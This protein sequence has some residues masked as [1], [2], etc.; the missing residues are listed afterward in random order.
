MSLERI[1][2]GFEHEHEWDHGA[3]LGRE[4]AGDGDR[5]L[6]PEA[7]PAHAPATEHKPDPQVTQRSGKTSSQRISASNPRDDQE[8]LATP[9]GPGNPM[10]DAKVRSELLRVAADERNVEFPYEARITTSRDPLRMRASASLSSAIVAHMPKGAKVTVTGK[11]QNHFRPIRY[12]DA[13]HP[14]KTWEGWAFTT[15]LSPPKLKGDQPGTPRV[16]I[17][18]VTI[19][20]HAEVE[21]IPLIPS[22]ITG[23]L[24]LKQP[25]TPEPKIADTDGAI[26][27]RVVDDIKKLN[28]P[29]PS[30]T[31][32][33]HYKDQYRQALEAAGR[34]AEWDRR[35][36]K[37]HTDSRLWQQPYELDDP[38]TFALVKGA[39]ASEGLRQFLAG[40]TVTDCTTAMVAIELDAVRAVVGDVVFDRCFGNPDGPAKIRQ[41]KISQRL[42]ETPLYE[43][44]RFTDG[45]RGADKQRGEMGKRPVKAGEWYY[46]FNHPDYVEKHP[47]GAWRG[48]NALCLGEHD[49]KQMWSGFGETHDEEGMLRA[50]LARYNAPR[51]DADFSWLDR[52]YTIRENWP[53]Q[54]LD[55]FSATKPGQTPV[56][57]NGARDTVNVDQLIAAQKTPT[58][59]KAKPGK[60]QPAP[61]LLPPKQKHAAGLDVSTGMVLSTSKLA[62]LVRAYGDE[63]PL[64]HAL[65]D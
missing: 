20:V 61:P 38:F 46:F 60:G 16:H 55:G 5:E 8:A 34:S 64:A 27:V 2:P 43:L 33:L 50:L 62:D 35:W 26:A 37:G 48:E 3:S 25:T 36:E 21:P 40:L 31:S 57:N 44:L 56:P 11:S 1:R 54:Y 6:Q 45:A 47:G 15:Y 49:G 32:G 29:A 14:D 7:Q 53:A 63:D 41:L 30:L 28:G 12:V 9:Q 23:E 42:S 58:D 39:S 24:T 52:N 13:A 51:D 17:E 10:R 22:P 19:E 18:P 59:P 4:F 65:G